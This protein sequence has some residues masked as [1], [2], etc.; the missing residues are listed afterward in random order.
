[1]HIRV[2]EACT[3]VWVLAG[4]G[5]MLQCTLA[6]VFELAILLSPNKSSTCSLSLGMIRRRSVP[7]NVLMCGSI[8]V[9]LP[10]V[11]RRGRN[12]E[13]ISSRFVPLTI[14][15]KKVKDSRKRPGVAQRVPGDLGSQIF[16][17][18]GT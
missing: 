13:V 7:R 8:S 2:N 3:V 5:D 6:C 4:P 12:S 9:I 17:T 10:V 16:M 11:S 15:C 14:S 18:F 1:M